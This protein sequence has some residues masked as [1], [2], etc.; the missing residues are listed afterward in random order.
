MRIV[1]LIPGTG[2][3]YCGSCLR[4]NTL[5]HALR[6]R[7]HDVLMVPLYLPFMLEGHERE[8]NEPVFLGGINMYLQQKARLFARL[9]EWL[10][11]WLDSPGL[12]RWASKQSDMTGASELGDLT[13]STLRGRDGRQAAEVARLIEWLRRE[14]APDVVL[15]SNAMLC[16]LVEPL[17]NEIGAPIVC[18]LQ[19]EAP[20]LDTLP[21]VHRR[22]A[23]ELLRRQ[24][25]GVRRFIAVSRYYGDLMRS[26]MG[27]G[28]GRV[29]IIYNGIDLDD[30]MRPAAAPRPNLEP[31]LGYLARLC[32][33]KGLHTLCE[34]YIQLKK[35]PEFATLKLRAAGAMLK[36]DRPFVADL[37]RRLESAGV[38]GDA[39]F[40]PNI[41]RDAKI[42]LLR[43]LDVL[44]VPATYGE[45]FGLYVVEAL[46][47]G[48]P[49]VQP[50]HASFPELIEQT[51]G[52]MLCEPDD[53]ESLASALAPLLLDRNRAVELGR[54]GQSRV[55]EH[56]NSDRMARE[57]EQV[58]MMLTSPPAP[59]ARSSV[60]C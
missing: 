57:V 1:Q 49:V 55:R 6:R 52:G 34:A 19:G 12:L 32:A 24:T 13:I 59:A 48:V 9:P 47:C 43:S 53:P 25:A 27:I 31:T 44:S 20:F 29:D 14:P 35:R 5:G 26:R 58:C 45:S 22:E 50:R 23:W 8:E 10:T 28:E 41:E 40:M 46:A 16:G 18:T 4:D 36:G 7:G 38:L 21:P 42:D 51:G 54:T 33:D 39:E 30:L 60:P 11:R 56:F 17:H 3:F 2:S 15:L 37:Q